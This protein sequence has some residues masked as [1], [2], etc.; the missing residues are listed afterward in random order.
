MN[1]ISQVILS[2]LEGVAGHDYALNDSA[3]REELA[4]VLATALVEASLANLA[5]Y[6]HSSV[7]PNMLASFSSELGVN[8][9]AS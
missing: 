1:E 4:N 9:M 5:S 3:D 6:L 2:T 7:S 8:L